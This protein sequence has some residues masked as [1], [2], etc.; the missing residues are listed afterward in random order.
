MKTKNIKKAKGMAIGMVFLLS[1]ISAITIPAISGEFEPQALEGNCNL[2]M[3]TSYIE[4]GDTFNVTLYINTSTDS[5]TGFTMRQFLFNESAVGLVNMTPTLAGKNVSFGAAWYDAVMN[6]DGNLDNSTGNL[7]YVMGVKL[8][9]VT[10]NNSAVIMNFTALGCGRVNFT[11]PYTIWSG[12][13]GLIVDLMDFTNW[14]N[15]TVIILPQDPAAIGAIAINTTKINVTFSAGVGD[16]K[17]TLCGKEG[18][19]PTS[20][21]DSLLYNGTSSPFEHESLNPC[22]TYYYR[23]WGWNETIGEH[24]YTYRQTTEKT[25][26]LTNFSFAGAVPTNNS[27]TANCT[28]NIA[29]NVTVNNAQGAGVGTYD[30]WINTTLALYN[31]AG[32]GRL[33]NSS[34]PTQTMSGCAHNTTYW[35]NVTVIDGAGDKAYSNYTFITGWGGGTKPAVP[36]TPSPSHGASDIG[37]YLNLMSVNVSDVDGDPLNVTFYWRN[38]T[39][40]G[41]VTGVD[42][43]P[44]TTA[45]ITPGLNL[46]SETTYQWYVIA[47]DGCAGSIRRGPVS[48][49]W[50]FTTVGVSINVIKEWAVY[51]NN[52]IHAWINLTNNGAENITDV[53]VTEDYPSYLDFNGSVPT[54]DDVNNNTWTIPFLNMTGYANNTFNISIWLLLNITEDIANGTYFVNNVTA[55]TTTY[56]TWEESSNLTLG[57]CFTK[58]SNLSYINDSI[59]NISFWINVTNCGDFNLSGINISDTYWTNLTFVSSWPSPDDANNNTWNISFLGPAETQ[60]IRIN[61]SVGNF[62]NGT[63]VYNNATWVTD[64][65]TNGS[66]NMTYLQY[67]AVTEQ[68]RINYNTGYF[69]TAG[70]GDRVI[71]ILGIV[72]ILGAIF[73]VLV[74][75]RSYGFLGGGE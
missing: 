34:T 67:G 69:D 49:W 39:E 21:T 45:S 17:V 19:F 70:I 63:M 53:L 40:I 47:D 54:A 30:W 11:I 22:T 7:T 65:G 60:S 36:T 37:T 6:D 55:N 62:E 35:W 12:Q 28:Y 18:S 1:L 27:R 51:E 72:L 25:D 26:C 29:V 8:G 73:L 56:I 32:T 57:M 23:V 2:E 14:T 58:E 43:T 61:L 16:D 24:S 50:S 13:P 46:A 38:G 74:I 66:V 71:S 41:N 44:A 15:Q 33:F 31:W 64:Q 48:G 59:S 52:S 42:A 75:M 9:G 4:I 20:P 3:S 10:G 68:L 5:S